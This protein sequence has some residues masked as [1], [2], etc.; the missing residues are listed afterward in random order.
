MRRSFS[1]RSLIVRGLLATAVMTATTV[2]A[3]VSGIIVAPSPTIIGDEYTCT[4]DETNNNDWISNYK[5]EA[6]QKYADGCESPYI[7]VEQGETANSMIS[8]S[9]VPSTHTIRLTVTYLNPIEGEPPPPPTVHTKDITIAKADS[10]QKAGGFDV[11]TNRETG[12]Q[13]EY[14]VRSGSHNCGLSLSGTAQERLSNR[15]F[16]G[17]QIPGDSGW[18]P[19]AYSETFHLDSGEILDTHWASS[20][21]DAEWNSVQD[22]GVIE[23]ATQEL[24][25]IWTDPNSHLYTDQTLGSVNIVHRKVSATT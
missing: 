6:K 16:L 22:G 18:I 25:I 15:V 9:S 13:I 20:L 1:R 11:A 12:V 24:R 3:A 17:R 5:W 10:V 21:S 14:Q 8:S 2:L 7:V 19:A 4:A 23:S